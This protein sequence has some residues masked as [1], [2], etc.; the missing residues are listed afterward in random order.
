MFRVP[1]TYDVLTNLFHPR[2]PKSHL[3]LLNLALLALQV[4]LFFILSRR[5]AQIFFSCYFVF[6]RMAYDGGLG[7]ILTKQSKRRWIVREIQRL[8]WLDRSKRPDVYRWIRR[9]L[10]GKMGP[11]YSFDVRYTD[12]WRD[13]DEDLPSF[14]RLF[15][16]NITRGSSFA[17]SW[18]L[19]LLSMYHICAIWPLSFCSSDFLSYALFAFSCCRLPQG[20]SIVLHVLRWV[21]GIGLIAFNIWVKTEAHRIVKDYGW[22]WGDCFFERGALVFDG[23]F[24]MAPHPMYSVGM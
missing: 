2:R 12:E 7:W 10:Q 1:T 24:E 4:L 6:W 21:C 23:V 20:L 14:H 13:D 3:D 17:N 9:Q 22:Y 19:F 11:D 18:I 8:G 16:Q 5:S 15:P